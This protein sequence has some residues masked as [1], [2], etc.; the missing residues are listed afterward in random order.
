M[1]QVTNL[2][3]FPARRGQSEA[4]GAAIWSLVEAL[5]AF[6]IAGPLAHMNLV[7]REFMNIR[8]FHLVKEM[9]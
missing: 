9:K 3:F 6:S 1:S 2:A 7:R 5:A 8:N 4:L